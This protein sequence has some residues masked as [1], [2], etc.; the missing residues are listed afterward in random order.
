MLV[1]IDH[2]C[3]ELRGIRAR[4]AF[5]GIRGTGT[6]NSRQRSTRLGVAGTA[7]GG[8]SLYHRA[9]GERRTPA[10]RRTTRLVVQL[11]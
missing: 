9:H 2:G 5:G 3:A 4:P 10:S 8:E 1:P 11:M 6:I 7:N